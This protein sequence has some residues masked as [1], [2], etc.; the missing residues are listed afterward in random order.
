MVHDPWPDQEH[1]IG[2][3][4]YSMGVCMILRAIKQWLNGQNV[5]LIIPECSWANTS[6]DALWHKYPDIAYHMKS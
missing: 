1:V 6:K 5:V 3:P 2:N 4:P